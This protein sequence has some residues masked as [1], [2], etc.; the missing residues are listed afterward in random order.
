VDIGADKVDEGVEGWGDVMSDMHILVGK[1]S[2]ISELGML[3]LL[4]EMGFNDWILGS[5]V[6]MDFL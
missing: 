5:M 2:L 3:I 6:I 4:R 1:G